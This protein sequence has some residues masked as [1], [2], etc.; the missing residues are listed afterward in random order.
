MYFSMPSLAFSVP[1]RAYVMVP[2]STLISYIRFLF[3]F[4]Y[5]FILFADIS[6]TISSSLL[7]PTDLSFLPRVFE[8]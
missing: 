3:L 6:L 2:E 8:I 7:P 4:I 5:L 1:V